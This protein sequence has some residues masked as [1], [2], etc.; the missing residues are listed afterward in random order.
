MSRIVIYGSYGFTGNLISE[1]ASTSEREVVISGRDSTQLRQQAERLSLDYIPASL[2]SIEGL[3]TLLKGAGVVIHCAG[4]FI[5]TWQPMAEACIRNGCHYLDITGEI[6]VFEAMKRMSDEFRLRGLMAMPGVG[7][8][9]VPT[10]CMAAHLKKVLP[11]ATHLELAFWGLGGGV[12]RGTAKTMIRN[13]GKGGRV[14]EDCVLKKVPT[15]HKVR[16]I[17]FVEKGSEAVSIPWGDLSTG[18]TSTAIP[19]IIVYMAAPT[20]LIRI[21]KLSNYF[22]PLLRS[23][24][25]K[26][27]FVKSVE[28]WAPGPDRGAMENGASLIWGEVRNASGEL[29]TA[30][31]KTAEGYRLTAELA[32]MIACKVQSG[33]LKEGYQT[34]SAVFGE[35]LIFEHPDT[36][37]LKKPM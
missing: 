29:K 6:G 36:V 19:N 26:K 13:L 32:W 31:F 37:W 25:V 2:D 18:Y 8:D 23:E 14:R 1:I 28:K 35:S 12:S 34:P 10:D 33:F 11:D 9:V 7:F 21:M 15:A 5:D 3:D 24:F 4:P 30:V 17:H 27:R 16:R 22:G 20:K